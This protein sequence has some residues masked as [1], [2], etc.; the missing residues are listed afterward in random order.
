MKVSAERVLLIFAIG[1]IILSLFRLMYNPKKETEIKAGLYE[2]CEISVHNI[3]TNKKIPVTTGSIY[4]AISLQMAKTKYCSYIEDFIVT[5]TL[6]DDKSNKKG[7]LELPANF[8]ISGKPLYIYKLN[9]PILIH[10]TSN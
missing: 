4:E 9:Y 7:Y 3:K 5:V 10:E 8:K 6:C 2:I 1:A